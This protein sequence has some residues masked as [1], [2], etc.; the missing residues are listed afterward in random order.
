MHQTGGE[1][2][3]EIGEVSETRERLCVV[4]ADMVGYSAHTSKD[5]LGT[6]KMWMR[7]IQQIVLPTSDLCHGHI[8]RT[9]GDGI[10]L[11]FNSARDAVQW[12]LKT[13]S[14]VLSARLGANALYPGLSLRCAAHVCDA[15]A[16]GGDIY[17]NGV[18][19]TK[20]LQESISP[21]GIIVSEELF[22]ALDDDDIPHRRL[23]FVKMKNIDDPVCA[24]EVLL[25]NRA[26][27]VGLSQQ[28]QQLP[29]LA[30][31]PLQSLGGGEEFQYFADGVVEDIITSLTSLKELI[32][33]ARSSTLSLG[34][35]N[36]DPIQIGEILNVRYVVT[37]TLRRSID[38]IRI[39]IALCDTQTAEI[40]FSEQSEFPHAELFETQ[41]RIVQH[42]VSK[43]APNV[44]EAE[45]VST[46]RKPPENFTAYE[47][48][49]R[50]LDH[51]TYLD[52]ENFEQAFEYL[53]KA[54][55]LDPEFAMPVAYLVRWYCVYVGQGWSNNRENDIANA[56]Q[57][58]AK[59]I[60][61]DRY[62]ALA[63]ASYGHLKS[64]LE[65]DYDTA[66]LF[67]DRSREVGP[68]LA[69]AWM[70]SSATLSYMGRP[71]EALEQ[72]Q[73]GIRLSPNDQELFQF[74]DFLAIASYLNEDFEAAAHNCECSYSEKQD[75]TSNWKMMIVT[76]A[77][78]GRI[79]RAQ[80]F[81]KKL[82]QVTPD[83]KIEDYLRDGCP[84]RLSKDR[85]MMAQHLRIAGLT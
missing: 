80:E 20:R 47:L 31:M 41:D 32:V 46:M 33:I 76:N 43:I 64:Y 58:A 15:I 37:G 48:T 34:S 61:L 62:N 7:F 11:S 8:V 35:K 70:L 44:R 54:I 65:R 74:Y 28:H 12:C 19:I 67:L 45:R 40:V 51:M 52:K 38:R 60:R 56:K 68:S 1:S 22:E 26:T 13:Q 73:H 29:S 55:K 21:D 75:Y 4:F 2:M 72:A 49:L 10:L 57:V 25:E 71:V 3:S 23:G 27:S 50:A 18:N 78:L 59:A 17:G 81:V 85:H 36:L 66:L 14:Q 63:L 30:V 82:L 24:Y 84:F 42:I 69:L 39:S 77:A 9:L 83:F 6:H 53:N 16:E 5:E 79:E